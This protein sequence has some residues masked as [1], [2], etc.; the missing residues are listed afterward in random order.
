VVVRVE[1]AQGES[2]PLGHGWSW[3]YFGED[4]SLYYARRAELGPTFE[5][6]AGPLLNAA[7]DEHRFELLNFDESLDIR[8]E[9]RWQA[10]DF[11]E[12]SVF[13][14][15]FLHR[16]SSALALAELLASL[17][18]SLLVLVDEPVHAR[19]LEIVARQ[20]GHDVQTERSG[21]RAA[22]RRARSQLGLRA[23]GLAHRARF[24]REAGQMR[25]ALDNAVADL[26]AGESA[27][28]LLVT[29][30]DPD[31]FDPAGPIDRDTFLGALPLALRRRGRKTVY[32]ANLTRWV[33]PLPTLLS[34]LATARDPLIVAE[35]TLGYRAALGIAVRTLRAPARI[36]RPLLVGQLDL[37]VLLQDELRREWSKPRQLWALQF[38]RV[39]RL[40]AGR[41]VCPELV[42][43]PYENQSWEK[44]LRIGLRSAFPALE[45]VGFQHTPISA[46]WFSLYPSRRDFATGQVPDRV[47]VIGELWRR[48]FADLGWAN[49]RLSVAPALR[50]E[51]GQ[52]GAPAASRDVL[53]A[54]S[55]GMDDS[56]ELVVKALR[57][58]EPVDGVGVRI[59]LHPK[60]GITPEAFAT[61]IESAHDRRLER[62]SF[63]TGS[64]EDALAGVGLALY[65]TTSVAYQALAAGVP[66]IFVESDFWFDLDSIPTGA[67]PE[68]SART[69][70]EIAR[71]AA[72]LLDPAS[73][74][75]AAHIDAGRRLIADAFAEGGADEFA[76][77]LLL[78]EPSRL[79]A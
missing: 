64:V 56:I 36:R 68:R 23:R 71:L 52:P 50:Y 59:K 19:R 26:A 24:V 67:G 16:C 35:Q 9:L 14:S 42:V 74:E 62:V 63:V 15:K 47:L 45:V 48:L 11:A 75:R 8:D 41:G 25:R 31:T 30:V 32:L 43:H 78:R 13:T 51:L 73:A 27:D 79:G 1:L 20:L 29:W 7:V 44:L 40:L 37:S 72:R 38:E 10:T 12:R 53:V 2:A 3:V 28:T 77:A 61:E 17:E 46:R 54:C 21:V 49:D 57:A 58:F 39:G 22:G 4:A 5:I 6:A 33:N 34:N 60:S 66:V 76:T 69:S 55:I 65:N 18:G 70:D